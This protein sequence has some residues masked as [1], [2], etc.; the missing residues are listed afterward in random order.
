MVAYASGWGPLPPPPR[1]ADAQPRATLL[2]Q[3]PSLPQLC[4]CAAVLMQA[5][6]VLNPLSCWPPAAASLPQQA[7]A[8]QP[9]WPLPTPPRRIMILGAGPIVIGQACE[10]DYSGTQACKAL[11]C[12][13]RPAA[14]GAAR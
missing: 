10:F 1:L 6:G 7:P 13:A 5:F 14:S 8:C 2:P 3:Q 12:V 11:K 4:R 9:C